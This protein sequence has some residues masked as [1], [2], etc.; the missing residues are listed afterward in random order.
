[1]VKD[2]IASFGGKDT[3]K[4]GWDALFSANNNARNGTAVM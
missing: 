2:S 4:D 1:M 3:T